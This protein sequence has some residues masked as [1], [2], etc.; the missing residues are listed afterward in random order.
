[1][2]IAESSGEKKSYDF[3][4]ITFVALAEVGTM[5]KQLFE[6]PLRR[7]YENVNLHHFCF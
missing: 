3:W 1:M 4:A 7:D 6:F 2:D 5:R